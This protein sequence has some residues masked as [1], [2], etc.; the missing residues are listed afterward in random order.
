MPELPDV[1]TYK[2]YLDATALH[3]PIARIRVGA[4]RLL[5]G[6]SPQ[7]L[8]RR[9]DGH[10]LESTGRHGKYLFVRVD[11]AGWLVLHFGMTGKLRYAKSPDSTP[12]HVELLLQFE[13]GAALA[14]IA[15]RK[16][17]RIDWAEAPDDYVA[18][19]GLG[20]DALRLDYTTFR[21]R[22]RSRRGRVKS[23]LMNQAALAGIG[24]IYSDEILFQAKIHPRRAVAELDG[25]TLQTLHRVLGRVLRQAIDAHANPDSMPRSFLLPHRAAGGRC[26]RC[27]AQVDAIRVAGRT[28]YYCPRCQPEGECGKP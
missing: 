17:G 15:P 10:S 3:Q 22:A 2:R 26:P 13:N 21:E 1:E 23:W 18:A 9:L 6:I 24:N 27:G 7:A 5:H 14:Y 12:R 16:L 11:E 28:S 19:R 20:P 25:T 4:Q 8:G